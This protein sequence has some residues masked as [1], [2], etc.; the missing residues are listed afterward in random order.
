MLVPTNY[1]FPSVLAPVIQQVT[2]MQSVVDY[3]LPE[4]FQFSMIAN[5]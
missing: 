4:T 2:V 3:L 5:N 1:P